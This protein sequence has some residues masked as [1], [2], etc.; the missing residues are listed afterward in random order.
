MNTKSP[1]HLWFVVGMILIALVFTLASLN[2]V[3]RFKVESLSTAPNQ[4]MGQD[5]LPIG[6]EFVASEMNLPADSQSRAQVTSDLT[7]EQGD[8]IAMHRSQ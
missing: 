7:I 5:T 3:S 2:N 6:T 1:S 8:L 4:Q